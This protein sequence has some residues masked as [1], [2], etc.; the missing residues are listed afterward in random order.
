MFLSASTCMYHFAAC[1]LYTVELSPPINEFRFR[2]FIYAYKFVLAT[3]HWAALFVTSY[4]NIW[5]FA[6]DDIL[7]ASSNSVVLH[8]H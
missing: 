2:L 3:G 8:H 4:Y 5:L 7:L 1:M 6:A